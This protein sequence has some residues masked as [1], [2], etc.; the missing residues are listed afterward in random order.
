MYHTTGHCLEQRADQPDCR[1]AGGEER[2][3]TY[4]D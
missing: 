2:V 4:F 1:Q 3:E